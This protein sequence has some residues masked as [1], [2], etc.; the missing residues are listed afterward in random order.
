MWIF[1][2]TCSFSLFENSNNKKK[3]LKMFFSP[4]LPAGWKCFNFFRHLQNSVLIWYFT[5]FFK[6]QGRNFLNCIF[7]LFRQWA[8]NVQ[9]WLWWCVPPLEHF[10]FIL[11]EASGATQQCCFITRQS[12][13]KSR[14]LASFSFYFPQHPTSLSITA[15][16]HSFCFCDPLGQSLLVLN[17][18]LFHALW[19]SSGHSRTQSF[20]YLVVPQYFSGEDGLTFPNEDNNIFMNLYL[21]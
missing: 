4:C 9:R 14:L 5:C 21:I 1:L 16:L 19:I 11:K 12:K 18:N 3:Y 10:L 20:L 13:N 8:N 17:K 7:T 15:H 2:H 6:L